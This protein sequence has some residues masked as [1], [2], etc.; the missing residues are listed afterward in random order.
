MFCTTS[1]L[2]LLARWELFPFLHVLLSLRSHTIELFGMQDMALP[3][4][5]S[6]GVY[7]AGCAQNIKG[8]QRAG[9]INNPTPDLETELLSELQTQLPGVTRCSRKFFSQDAFLQSPLELGSLESLSP[10]FTPSSS[11]Q[12]CLYM[13]DSQSLTLRH[14]S[15][16]L[17]P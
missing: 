17:A 2:P 11:S 4:L 15:P 14:F 9:P 3:G 8:L 5:P 10:I 7:L 1:L 6:K 12:T 13:A 16:T